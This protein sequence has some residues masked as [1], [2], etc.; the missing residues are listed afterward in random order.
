MASASWFSQPDNMPTKISILKNMNSIN[1]WVDFEQLFLMLSPTISSLPD[2]LVLSQL[3]HQNSFNHQRK[4][5]NISPQQNKHHPQFLES[6]VYS[7][8]IV[9]VSVLSRIINKRGLLWTFI[10]NLGIYLLSHIKRCSTINATELNFCVRNGNRCTLCAI[11]TKILNK[12]SCCYL[13][14]FC[15][16]YRNIVVCIYSVSSLY[17]DCVHTNIFNIIEALRMLH[18]FCSIPR[19]EQKAYINTLRAI[20]NAQL[21]IFLCFHLHPINLVVSKG[22]YPD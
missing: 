11:Y 22:T 20:S 14:C 18:L 9:V 16:C 19:K 3:S 6:G 4:Y 10:Q 7:V 2:V 12:N 5:L 17:Q 1:S 21:H 15:V 8:F 13:F